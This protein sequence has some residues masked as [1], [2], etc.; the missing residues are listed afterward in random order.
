MKERI[1][2]E[3]ENRTVDDQKKKDRENAADMRNRAMESHGQTKKRKES[4]DSDNDG[5]KLKKKV[6][7]QC[8]SGLSARKN[9]RL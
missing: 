1:A 7:E 4:D 3:S 6:K 2:A 5:R 8:N 9:E